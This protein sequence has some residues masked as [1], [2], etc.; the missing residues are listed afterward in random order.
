M[1][2]R[3]EK[4]EKKQPGRPKA[5]SQEFVDSFKPHIEDLTKDER[6]II[7]LK[8]DEKIALARKGLQQAAIELKKFLKIRKPR[9]AGNILHFQR[10]TRKE[11]LAADKSAKARGAKLKGVPKKR[12]AKAKKR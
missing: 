12:K 1:L 10:I 9:D 4:I 7:E 2:F 11:W 3:K 8:K 6:G 5:L